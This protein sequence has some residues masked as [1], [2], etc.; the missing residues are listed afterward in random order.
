MTF[1]R[2][3][4]WL[5]LFW[6]SLCQ[7]MSGMMMMHQGCTFINLAHNTRTDRTGS[8]FV[9]NVCA[10]WMSQRA[11]LSAIDF[12]SRTTNMMM[13]SLSLMWVVWVW[14]KSIIVRYRYWRWKKFQNEWWWLLYIV[15][16]RRIF[17]WKIENSSAWISKQI[18]TIS[19]TC[20]KIDG[21]I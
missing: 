5:L 17:G 7:S 14:Y 12:N 15:I 1:C 19:A 20:H 21:Q 9:L 13:A 10:F 18:I 11:F 8:S 3:V 16:V 4:W 2:D 6:S